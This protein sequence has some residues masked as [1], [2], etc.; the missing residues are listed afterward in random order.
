LTIATLQATPTIFAYIMLKTV[1]P[2]NVQPKRLQ[3]AAG[4]SCLSLTAPGLAQ[5]Y[6]GPADP[7]GACIYEEAKPRIANLQQQR[8]L[9][10]LYFTLFKK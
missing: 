5:A 3:A 9:Y 2:T 10:D 7:A 8:D 1:L 6:L 4:N